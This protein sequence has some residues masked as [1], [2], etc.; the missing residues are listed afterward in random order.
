MPIRPVTTLW[1][2]N[3]MMLAS[4]PVLA[5]ARSHLIRHLR[6]RRN[7]DQPVE[8]LR[9]TFGPRF[10]HRFDVAFLALVDGG[11]VG[12]V[13]HVHGNADVGVH[14]ERAGLCTAQA[15]LLLHCGDGEKR[16]VQRFR[17]ARRSASTTTHT[18]VMLSMPGEFAS[19]LRISR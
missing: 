5:P 14:A 2:A 1:R 19:P 7:V 8:E 4:V 11:A 17:A 16:A 15:D 9:L 6:R 13:G 10:D 12:G 18:P 3:W